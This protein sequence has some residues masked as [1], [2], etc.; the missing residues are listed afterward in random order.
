VPLFDLVEVDNADEGAL[1]RWQH[2]L[3]ALTGRDSNLPEW[4]TPAN[5]RWRLARRELLNPGSAGNPCYHIE[6]EPLDGA[7]DW[8]AGDIAV[9]ALTGATPHSMA[10]EIATD[11]AATTTANATHDAASSRDTNSLQLAGAV[12]REYSIASL[13]SDGALHILV[14]QSRR[15][16]G[17]LGLASGWLTERAPIGSDVELRIRRNANFHSPA[18]ARPMILIGNGT[19]IAGLRSHLKAREKAGARRNWLIFGE[20]NTRHDTFYRDDIERWRRSGTLARID[21]AFSRDQPE[22]IY[23]Q[24]LIQQNRRAIRDWVADGAAIYVCG[25]ATGMSPA[26]EDALA[27]ALGRDLFEQLLTERRFRRDVY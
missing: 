4:N 12:T 6:F 11:G 13:P 2:Q 16:D 24:H 20:R 21:L 8:L 15:P 1:R 3:A 17:S 25:S 27:S 18:G 22:R 10:A 5:S 23:V 14:R 19:G 9:V 7:A 26:V